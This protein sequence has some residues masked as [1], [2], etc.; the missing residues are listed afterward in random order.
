MNLVSREQA[1]ALLHKTIEEGSAIGT[2]ESQDAMKW[3][4]WARDVRVRT[5]AVFGTGSS[6]REELAPLLDIFDLKA[7]G[8]EQ[9]KSAQ[10]IL[11]LLE[12]F[13]TE[14][15]DLWSDE[16]LAHE[17]E[18]KPNAKVPTPIEKSSGAIFLVHGHDQGRMQ[19]VARFLEHIGLKPIILHERASSGDTVIEKLERHADASFAVVLLTPD[20][21]GAVAS[22]PDKLQPR[23]RQ[24]VVLEL[25]YFIARLGRQRTCALLV[26]GVEIPSD[27]SGVVYIPIK[28]GDEWKL[29][30]AREL[31]AG[32]LPIDVD[33]VF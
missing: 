10:P 5:E 21:V 4:T 3:R 12:S 18:P 1:L 23:A 26:P 8:W 9:H 29:L 16:P 2:S 14:V 30:L 13:Y 24:N 31:R 25:G 22:R 7:A 11:A 28:E 19:A 33:K 32:G 27:Y 20:D 15:F 17:L 6:Q